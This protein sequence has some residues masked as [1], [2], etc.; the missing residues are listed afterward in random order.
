M[1]QLDQAPLRAMTATLASPGAT[2][3]HHCSPMQDRTATNLSQYARR[4]RHRL[5]I[6][7]AECGNFVVLNYECN[8]AVC[9]VLRA[10]AISVPSGRV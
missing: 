5:L 7:C 2:P 3:S 9:Q 1:A 6:L 4:A 8:R 10:G